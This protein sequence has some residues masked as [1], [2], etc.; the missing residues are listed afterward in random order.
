MSCLIG[1]YFK[2]GGSAATE[3]C[4]WVQVEIDVCIPLVFSTLYCCHSSQKS[5]FSFVQQNKSPKSKVK[6]TQANNYC[7]RVFKDAEVA[8]V[9]KTE[10]SIS[11]QKLGS[12]D[13][14]QIANSVLNKGISDIPPL[15]KGLEVMFSAFEE[16]FSVL[17]SMFNLVLNLCG[18]WCALRHQ[19]SSKH[20]LLFAKPPPLKSTNCTS[21]TFQTILPYILFFYPPPCPPPPTPQ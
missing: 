21:P 18:S 2:L 8:N 12:H 10:K 3:F 5:L 9:V 17:S 14:W 13:F 20:P 7:K 19:P 6:F 15:F 11:S 1:E 16:M 4:E